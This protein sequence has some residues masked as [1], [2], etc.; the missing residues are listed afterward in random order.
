MTTGSN[1]EANGRNIS[2][3]TWIRHRLS[4]RLSL[5]TLQFRELSELYLNGC[6]LTASDGLQDYVALKKLDLGG[7]S[8]TDVSFIARLAPNLELLDLS[9]NEITGS[10][11]AFLADAKKLGELK[12]DSIDLSECQL[13]YLENASSLR[14]LY[15][16]NC[17]LTDISGIQ[18]CK[19][20]LQIFLGFNEI[21]DIS[22]LASLYIASSNSRILDLTDNQ[23]ESFT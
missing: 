10:D 2:L 11:L 6:G 17:G 1:R 7:N 19:I 4:L 23:I 18:N 12:L 5:T 21:N 20:L 15:A 8:L 14:V 3:R 16:R 9:G 22:P 13:S